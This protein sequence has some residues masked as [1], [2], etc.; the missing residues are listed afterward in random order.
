[1]MKKIKYGHKG[2]LAFVSFMLAFENIVGGVSIYLLRF[3]TD[4]GINRQLD[5]MLDIAK[6][7][8]VLLV[9][10]LIVGVLATYVK[11]TYKERSLQ[12]MKQ[13]YVNELLKQDITQLQKEHAVHYRSHLTNDFDN[14]EKKYLDNVLQIISMMMQLIV[15]VVLVATISWIL[16]VIALVLFLIF[17]T[18]SSSSNKPVQK[19]EAKKSA[20][21][22]DYTQ[23][24][25]E[26]LEGFEI[27]KQHQ[28]ENIRFEK[29]K[30]QAEQVQIDNY[31]VDVKTTYVDALVR[32]FQSSILFGL[33]IVGILAAKSYNM[34]LGSIIVVASSFG[35]A[36][37][38]LQQFS[39]VIIEMKGIEKVLD[40]FD[41][42]L[43]RPIMH[44]N[45]SLAH[46]NQLEF[47]ACDLGYPED[48]FSI[49]H[50]VN[51]SV[52]TNDKVLII[53]PS[54]AGK[55]TILKTIRQSILPKSGHVSVNNQ[56][57]FEIN[58]LDYYS[59]FATVDQIGFIFNGTIFENVTLFKDISPDVVREALKRV[60]LDD[61]KLE[62]I[63]LN[64]GAN[65]SGGQRARL[66]LARA[67]VLDSQII[68]CDE[69]FANLDL[70]VAQS[71]E[72][73]MLHL[74]QT[75]INVSHVMFK[76]NLKYY[77]RIYIVENSGVHL[78]T[79]LDE[80]IAKMSLTY[81]N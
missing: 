49:L 44:R 55:S 22:S 40:S 42:Y 60:N 26:T 47:K 54:G 19:S 50:D 10:A 45:L 27:I 64:N 38:P 31:K 14:F 5:K 24:V 51:L 61:F 23:L 76:E 41:K 53:G 57:I 68:L 73:D 72:Y 17:I 37:W 78:S 66:L 28:L 7:M 1:M 77:D 39:T 48:D 75:I 63:L 6:L 62:E 34:G 46:F 20:S 69:V 30:Q 43:T 74:D 2:W 9:V 12:L 81:L 3:V 79:S 4:Y 15:T 16:V 11:A 35:S 56:N 70:D 67:L 18:I 21:L 65:I 25:E 58:P 36:M 13:H 33:I 29:F 71:I 80:V 32:F 8:M 59:L 52:N